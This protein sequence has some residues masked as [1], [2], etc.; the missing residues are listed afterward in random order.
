MKKQFLTITMAQQIAEE[1]ILRRISQSE[2]LAAYQFAPVVL[3]SDGEYFWTFVSGSEQLQRE[4]MVPGALHA[5][6]DKI[7]GHVWTNQEMEEFFTG[8]QLHQSLRREKAAA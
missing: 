4:G 2:K 5:C 7:D 3:E 6:V 8:Q 1:N